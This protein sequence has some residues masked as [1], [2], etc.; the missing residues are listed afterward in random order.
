MANPLYDSVTEKTKRMR[1]AS[2]KVRDLAND[3]E[4][5]LASHREARTQAQ[6]LHTVQPIAIPGIVPST[7]VP[8]TLAPST[9]ATST[10]SYKCFSKLIIDVDDDD[11]NNADNSACDEAKTTNAESSSDFA[12][13]KKLS[14]FA[15]TQLLTVGTASGPLKRRRFLSPSMSPEPELGSHTLLVKD[16]SRDVD[17]LFEQ[18]ETVSGK[19]YRNCKFCR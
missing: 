8:S 4:P 18:P 11:N 1:I 2:S 14:A 13:G 6:R 5:A 15:C 9:I 3:A 10:S 17:E 12:E 16:R 19:K 7:L